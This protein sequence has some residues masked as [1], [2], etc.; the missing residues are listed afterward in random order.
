VAG[1]LDILQDSRW[2]LMKKANVVGVGKGLKRVGGVRTEQSSITVLVREK[3]ALSSLKSSD[4]IPKEINGI[5]TDVFEVGELKLLSSIRTE[6]RRPAQPGVSIGHYKVTAGTL[7]AL[8]KDVATGQTLLLSNNHV[9]A[10]ISNGK[11]GRA[12]IGD[13]VLQPGAYD[14][15]KLDS[16]VIGTLERFVPLVRDSKEADC[17]VASLV[18]GILNDVLNIIYPAYTLKFMKS[19]KAENTV[20]CALAK[21]VSSEMVRKDILEIGQ[22]KG[23]AEVGEKT[24]V[25]KSGRTTGLTRGEVVSTNATVSVRLSDNENGI[26]AD[27]IVATSISQGGDSGSLVLNED[28][29][30]VGLL[31]AGSDKATIFNRIQN[32]LSALRV[33]LL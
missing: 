31:F 6:K 22:V 26:F 14:G 19:L 32:V 23:I 11:D 12:R 33:E 8:V 21:P 13:P 18:S 17:Q 3:V 9:F 16:D 25:K 2:Q 4:V 30:A 10:N 7:G 15:G 1:I 24:K 28:N 20:D 29:A 27:Q 5:P